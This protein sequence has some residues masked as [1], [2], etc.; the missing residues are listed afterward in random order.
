MLALALHSE[1]VHFHD[2][3]EFSH[4]AFDVRLANVALHRGPFSLGVLM[5]NIEESSVHEIGGG[6]GG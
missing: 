6:A 1:D 4:S 2:M 3:Y 5:F